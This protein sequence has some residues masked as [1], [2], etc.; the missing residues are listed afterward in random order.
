MNAALFAILPVQPMKTLPNSA[1]QS[2]W[3]DVIAPTPSFGALY[4]PFI[5]LCYSCRD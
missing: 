2:V 3:R 1:L 5:S 4:V